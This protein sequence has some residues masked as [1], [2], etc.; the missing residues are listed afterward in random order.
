MS[1]ITVVGLGDDADLVAV[2]AAGGAYVQPAATGEIA[3]K[4]AD[5]IDQDLVVVIGSR[6]LN[7]STPTP[8]AAPSSALP[9]SSRNRPW[10]APVHWFWH[11]RHRHSS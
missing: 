1:F 9:L 3:G 4:N 11:R 6:V 7:S 2:S 8:V 10:P 5:L